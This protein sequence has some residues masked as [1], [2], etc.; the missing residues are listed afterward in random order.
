MNTLKEKIAVMNAAEQGMDIEYQNKY[1]NNTNWY[2]EDEPNWNWVECTYRIKI[3]KPKINI[4]PGLDTPEGMLTAVWPELRAL[5][6]K[7]NI[8]TTAGDKLGINEVDT[9]E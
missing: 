2:S 7:L 9:N 4:N 8:H 6:V 3:V 5:Y 1:G